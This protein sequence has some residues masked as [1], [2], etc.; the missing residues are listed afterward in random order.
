MSAS[1]K[2]L[3]PLLVVA[4][5]ITSLTGCGSILSTNSQG[6]ISKIQA[7]IDQVLPDCKLEE[8]K[9]PDGLLSIE[10]AEFTRVGR[11]TNRLVQFDY[12][13]AKLANGQTD[14]NKP[15]VGTSY[16]N[17]TQ[18]NFYACNSKGT[19]LGEANEYQDFWGED[20]PDGFFC[21]VPGK[22]NAKDNL[23]RL[24]ICEERLD[25]NSKLGFWIGIRQGTSSEEI[26]KFVLPIAKENYKYGYGDYPV[27]F[28][29]NLAIT[30]FANFDE[31]N[32]ATIQN[33]D[34]AWKKL[35]KSLDLDLISNYESGYP[36]KFQQDSEDDFGTSSNEGRLSINLGYSRSLNDLA[37]SETLSISE[38]S[39]S[40][41]A[42]GKLEFEVFQSDLNTGDC[43]FLGY[44]RDNSGNQKIGVVNYCNK[45]A[46]G[47]FSEGMSYPLK[48]KI[49]G[50]TSYITK[51]G[52]K[53]NVLSFSAA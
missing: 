1:R 3:L 27:A 13:Y 38:I 18:D 20:L 50:S 15:L 6:D 36:E 28:Y 39:Y 14:M 33:I 26:Q 42:C 47:S 49:D 40:V 8:F 24:K 43:T 46:S 22:K 51:L 32:L 9:V 4:L 2:I 17:P 45:Y 12:V 23:R 35:V 44:W 52:Y 29:K 53:N 5:M 7:A 19:P 30:L 11:L 48:V 25:E 16:V 21:W 34:A 41:G 31:V 37:C 10:N